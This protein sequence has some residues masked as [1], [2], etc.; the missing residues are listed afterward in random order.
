[1]NHYSLC[2]AIK[3]V[4]A[5][6]W[7]FS[8]IDNKKLFSLLAFEPTLT[9]EP[10]PFPV[11]HFKR[12]SQNGVLSHHQ[13]NFQQVYLVLSLPSLKSLQSRRLEDNTCV[14]QASNSHA[15]LTFCSCN[16]SL[17]RRSV[18]TP[19]SATFGAAQCVAEFMHETA[20]WNV[21][22]PFIDWASCNA[23]SKDRR[24]AILIFESLVYKILQPPAFWILFLVFSHVFLISSTSCSNLGHR[25]ALQCQHTMEAGMGI[26]VS[27]PVVSSGLKGT[28]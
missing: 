9:T 1:M 7:D 26:A 17:P 19:I 21:H 18:E 16:M 15:P 25:S 10:L 27:S 8:N 6:V 14:S 3:I 23:D 20:A 24:T 5:W 2:T 22:L 11:P 12:L 13:R 4:G 28:R